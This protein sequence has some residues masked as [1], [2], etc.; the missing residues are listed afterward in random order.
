MHYKEK[1]RHYGGNRHYSV[2]C[3]YWLF[4]SMPSD[5]TGTIK[6]N[7]HY[8]TCTTTD[9]VKTMQLVLP[10]VTYETTFP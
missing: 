3:Q 5:L 2:H 1:Y 6:G 10:H 8:S 9:A 4:P 7:R